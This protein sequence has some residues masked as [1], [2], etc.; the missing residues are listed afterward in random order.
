M[1]N[2]REPV[3]L[4]DFRGGL[5]LRKDQLQ[6]ERNESPEMNNISLDVEGGI[7]TR[8]GFERVNGDDIVDPEIDEWDPRR[9]WVHQLSDGTDSIYIANAGT[10]L[11][12][13]GNGPFED[14]EITVEA[15][16]HMADFATWGDDFYI[17]AG[18]TQQAARRHETD[19]PELLTAGGT[20][21]WND[22][23]TDPQHG[24]FPQA[25]LIEAHAGYIFAA[26]TQE[27]AAFFPNRVRWSHPLNPDDWHSEDYIDILDGGPRITALMSFEDHLLIFKPDS[28]WALYGYDRESWQLVKKS[29][30][31]GALSPQA[32]TRSEGAV[33][34]YSPAERGAIFIYGGERPVEISE[35]IRPALQAMVN[36][37][38]VWVGW[39]ARKLWVTLP[40]SYER[41]GLSGSG[42]MLGWDP[43][44]RE[45]G[46]WVRF[47]SAE[48]SLGPIVGGSNVDSQL[49]PMGVLRDTETPCVVR[50]EAIE[51]RAADHIWQ[52]AVLGGMVGGEEVYISLDDGD[53]N[54]SDLEVEG[55]VAYSPF[56]TVYRTSWVDADWPTRR[57]SWRRPDIVANVTEQDYRLRVEAFRDYNSGQARRG[58]TV[59]VSSGGAGARWGEFEWGDGTLWGEAS[60]TQG[61]KIAR[62]SSWGLARSIQIRFVGLTPGARWGINTVVAKVVMRRFR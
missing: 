48:G 11:V 35:P 51:D 36:H 27:D 7:R 46:S 15:S 55:V 53:E 2:R 49:R 6:I 61:S 21:T 24:V 34:F 45:Q 1:A 18:R 60:G 16:P 56:E 52:Y 13:D 43:T 23:Y 12:S 19:P 38:L 39:I 33:F 25:E 58:A 54:E 44:L 59:E 26:N 22:D 31:C 17:A 40:W 20:A 50:L 10:I 30:T 32:V 62:G 5:N 14:L 9:A 41:G 57:K 3:N 47:T 28:V 4:V 8:R 29:A 37:D 42:D